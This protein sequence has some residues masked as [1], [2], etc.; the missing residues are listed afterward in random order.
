MGNNAFFIASPGETNQ[1][2]T[3]ID[4]A[5]IDPQDINIE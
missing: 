5:E 3:E 2:S 1:I 4:K